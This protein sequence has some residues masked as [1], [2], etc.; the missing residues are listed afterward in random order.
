MDKHFDNKLSFC[1]HNFLSSVK[2][3]AFYNIKTVDKQTILS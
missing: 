3:I 2:L 1:N